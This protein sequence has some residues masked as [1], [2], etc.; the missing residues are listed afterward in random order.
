ML[1]HHQTTRE[2]LSLR[3]F[4]AAST[5]RLPWKTYIPPLGPRKPVKGALK[6]LMLPTTHKSWLAVWPWYVESHSPNA[7][8]R[9]RTVADFTIWVQRK[10]EIEEE[11]GIY[12]DVLRSVCFCSSSN[13]ELVPRKLS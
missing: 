5:T 2:T 12:I 13:Q 7:Q 4:S 8:A 11:I 10:K 9:F 1:Y 6:T 3:P